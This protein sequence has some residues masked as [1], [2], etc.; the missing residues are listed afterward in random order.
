MCTQWRPIACY[1]C[2]VM[3]HICSIWWFFVCLFGIFWHV[4]V[5]FHVSLIL[6]CPQVEARTFHGVCD[7]NVV[8]GA[9]YWFAEADV[10]CGF[11]HDGVF[12]DAWDQCI[13]KDQNIAECYNVL[14]SWE[15][16]DDWS[17]RNISIIHE[18]IRKE[19][20]KIACCWNLAAALS[21]LHYKWLNLFT[22]YAISQTTR[23]SMSPRICCLGDN[24]G[25]AT[26]F[27]CLPLLSESTAM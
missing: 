14:T 11:S 2:V 15:L 24:M 18:P 26:I 19:V 3:L 21:K 1:S 9:L 6:A 20:R 8:C 27:D 17:K 22:A 16:N 10:N 25:F 7:C 23:F 13:C 5:I 4:K 12:L